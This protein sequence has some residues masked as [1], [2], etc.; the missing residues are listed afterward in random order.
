M[1]YTRTDDKIITDFF[2]S[3]NSDG[4][5]TTKKNSQV[6]GCDRS[7]RSMPN[8]RAVIRSGGFAATPF[9]AVFFFTRKLSPCVGFFT[10]KENAPGQKTFSESV[11]GYKFSGIP[12]FSNQVT[13]EAD[14]L[15]LTKFYS[16]LNKAQSHANGMQFL[17]EFHEVVTMF[18][19]PYRGVQKLIDTY[20]L[21][22]AGWVRRYRGGGSKASARNLK[23]LNKALADSWLETAFGL[24]PL[25]S[26]VKDLAE[27]VARFNL[28]HKRREIIEGKAEVPIFG[29]TQSFTGST[30]T[31]YIN[32]KTDIRESLIHQVR[33]RGYMDW[34]ASSDLGSSSQLIELA[35]FRLDKFIPTVYEL[36]PWSFLVD[37]F[38]NLGTVIEAGC[39]ST[40]AVKFGI[41]N[42]IVES[43]QQYS[44]T[45][46]SAGTLPLVNSNLTPGT[47]QLV[48]KRVRRLPF[49]NVPLVPLHFSIPGEPMK[50]LNMLA[51]W[52]SKTSDIAKEWGD[53]SFRSRTVRF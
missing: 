30:D 42:S 37:Y 52:K 19:H 23:N 15:A 2:V 29:S 43:M 50:Y 34:S 22:A 45:P 9:D 14:R 28:G 38:T 49:G 51:L 40:V 12:A 18:K 10:H 44:W 48:R 13:S 8:F 21:D 6:L 1:A 33:Y 35:G 36:I 24:R 17:G 5:S 53:P 16:N 7:G 41:Y 25:I 47:G 26:D 3:V 27:T 32:L 46:V 39:M 4:A 20:L 31:N 11:R